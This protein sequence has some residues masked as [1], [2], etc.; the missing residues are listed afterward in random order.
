V[1]ILNASLNQLTVLG[2]SVGREL[3]YLRKDCLEILK[4]LCAARVVTRG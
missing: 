3:Y 4:Q 1:C 2:S